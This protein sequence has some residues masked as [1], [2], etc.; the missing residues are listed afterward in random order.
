M[1]YFSNV[2][3]Q[4]VSLFSKNR[5]P[6]QSA[7]RFRGAPINNNANEIEGYSK[8]ENDKMRM[9]GYGDNG[10]TFMEGNNPY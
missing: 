9:G 7:L 6:S 5:K 1:D 8:Y 3:R 2:P 4:S 10:N